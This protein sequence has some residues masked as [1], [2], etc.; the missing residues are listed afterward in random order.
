[1][2]SLRKT[3]GVG[4]GVQIPPWAICSGGRE[5]DCKP[6]VSILEVWQS[7]RL[8]WSWKPEVGDPGP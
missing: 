7:G 5:A 4:S 2:V 8:R 6:K 1:M 3:K